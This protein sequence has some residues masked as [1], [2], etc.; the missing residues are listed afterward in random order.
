MQKQLEMFGHFLEVKTALESAAWVVV[1][2]AAGVVADCDMA[3][4]AL[5]RFR[6]C[7]IGWDQVVDDPLKYS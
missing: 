2:V 4:P 5:D 3:S 1:A 7:P 6:I